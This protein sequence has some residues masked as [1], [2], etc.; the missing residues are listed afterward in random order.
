[1]QLSMMNKVDQ[2]PH[3]VIDMIS[4]NR[5]QAN[6]LGY[7]KDIFV[8]YATIMADNFKILVMPHHTQVVTLLAFRKMLTDAEKP[9]GL[10]TL[11]A[12]VGTG[13]GKSMLIA[14][15]AAWIAQRKGKKVHVLHTD[16]R[17]SYRDFHI[18]QSLFKKLG[19]EKAV[20]LE[21]N[22]AKDAKN[23]D[24]M[25]ESVWDQ[26]IVYCLKHHLVILYAKEAKGRKN[27]D[28]YNN[29][30]LLCDEVDTLVIDEDPNDAI[31]YPNGSLG[32]EAQDVGEKLFHK[33]PA[34]RYDVGS[35]EHVMQ[36]QVTALWTKCEKGLL[37]KQYV[38][39]DDLEFKNDPVSCGYY[40][41]DGGGEPDFQM[42]SNTLEVLRLY[43]RLKRFPDRMDECPMHWFERLFVMSK[44]L[45]FRRY[46]AILGLSG[47]LGNE[48]EKDF[49]RDT[50]RAQFMDVPEFLKTCKSD[51]HDSE[52]SFYSTIWAHAVQPRPLKALGGECSISICDTEEEQAKKLAEIAF[53]ARWEVPV[54][55]IARD[56]KHARILFNTLCR[57]A[58]DRFSGD[59][60]FMQDL[61]QAMY[62]ES[63]RSYNDHLTLSTMR[64]GEGDNDPWRITVTDSSG[65]RGTDYKMSDG[66]ADAAGGLM[67]I[68]TE[69]P[70]LERDWVQFQGRTARQDNHGQMCAVLLEHDYIGCGLHR[71]TQA[72]LSSIQSMTRYCGE[73]EKKILHSGL[74]ETYE[75][76]AHRKGSY[77][78]GFRTNE[79]CEFVWKNKGDASGQ[80]VL[81]PAE[82]KS[83]LQLCG[84][85][86]T[87][88]LEQ[89]DKMCRQTVGRAPPRTQLPESYINEYHPE[90]PQHRAK[91]VL[92]LLDVSGSMQTK[93]E[94]DGKSRLQVCTRAAE[95]LMRKVVDES[96]DMIGLTTFTTSVD[97][98][99]EL[100]PAAAMAT[101]MS[102]L[103]Q[104][105]PL[106]TTAL[107]NGVIRGV[108]QLGHDSED[109]YLICLTDGLD[110]GFTMRNHGGINHPHTAEQVAHELSTFKGVFIIITVGSEFNDQEIKKWTNTLGDRGIH[111]KAENDNA[112][113]GIFEQVADT[114]E[115]DGGI[116]LS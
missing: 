5:S 102:K 81:N 40:A 59:D 30:I 11:I 28:K 109:C 7:F 108:E 66:D 113:E 73:V 71:P 60:H 4:K 17:L 91:S 34:K 104:L 92:F 39:K 2:D 24:E 23:A 53:K 98:I 89:M 82:K 10:K 114:L 88:A 25:W 106:Y 52:S 84:E 77:T 93:R 97:V 50:Y 95:S 103:D 41:N 46:F 1:L 100:Q 42:Q 83:F 62:L 16:E 94:S 48:G 6:V 12:R 18:Y 26:D 63:R 9:G 44:P 70:R 56:S 80:L 69:I 35:Q 72:D 27:F 19:I 75:L 79:L 29:Y 36:K 14:A 33:S 32:R 116:A 76:I 96:T 31:V 13:E 20:N 15:L 67:L 57:F 38:F 37:Q 54:L 55:V 8:T 21:P 90:K 51:G 86:K 111:F 3:K 78:A 101:F 61:S 68:L 85:Y 87:L 74:L 105:R 49:F 47:T 112:I 65:G 110:S 45:I 43:E 115:D 58:R 107:N 22:F 64:V 99:M